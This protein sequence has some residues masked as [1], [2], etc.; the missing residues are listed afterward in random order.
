MNPGQ[1][2]WPNLG[3]QVLDRRRWLQVSSIG[4]LS[5][6]LPVSTVNRPCHAGDRSPAAI[7]S[8]ILVFLY[9][10]PSQFETFDPKPLAPP[11][12]RGEYQAISTTV[13]GIAVCEHLPRVAKIMDRLALIRS[14]HHRLRNHNPAA[15]EVLTGR[16]PSGEDAE[17]LAEDSTPAIGSVV[18][19][20]LGSRAGVLPFV[21]LPYTIHN[22]VQIPGQTAGWLG[23]R[24]DR[25]QVTG[26]PNLPG[27]QVPALQP[28]A[29]RDVPELIARDELLKKL[30]MLPL[31]GEASKIPDLQ[32]RA[33][34]LVL[35]DTIRASFEIGR[36]LADARPLWAT[37]LGSKPPAGLQ[38]GGRRQ[39]RKPSLMVA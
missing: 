36:R 30:D 14:M 15:G 17:L 12:I 1:F 19:Y 7:K 5:G 6:A 20:A 33:L 18:S 8:C 10:G 24:Y 16:V 27:F 25:F 38:V 23:A 22:V 26:N 9:G 11:D 29:G 34:G 21:A 4:W 37:S 13:P 31:L 35:S 32:Q 2:D 39:F 28:T 3:S